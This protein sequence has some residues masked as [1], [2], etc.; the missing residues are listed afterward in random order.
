MLMNRPQVLLLIVLVFTAGC[1][2]LPIDQ[3]IKQERP[4][5]LLMNNS[6]DATA[7]FEMS[8]V[9]LPAE[10]TVRRSDGLNTTAAVNEGITV[11]DPGDN[12]T[13][14]AIELPDSARFHGRYAV[15][16]DESNRTSVDDLPR[17]FVI[18]VVVYQ[19][20][21]EIASY[22]TASCD[23][24]PLAALR[25]TRIPEGVTVTHSCVG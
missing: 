4:V 16:P 8:I 10:Y 1:G 21:D 7:T 3:P 24:L 9:Q 25:V 2:A 12:R 22:V 15:E 18:V 23:D 20:E 14:T 11:H 13:F 6:V 5:T 19:D 17:N